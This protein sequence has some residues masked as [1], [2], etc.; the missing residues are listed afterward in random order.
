MTTA[1]PLAEGL[2]TWPSAHPALLGSS[3]RQC[4]TTTFPAQG[5]CPRCTA[6]DMAPRELGRTGTLWSFTVQGFRPKDPYLGP[7][8]FRPYGVGYVEL[9]DGVIVE[10]VL[11]E[12]DPDAL[13]I[14][15]PM[16]LVVVPFTTDNPGRALVT[17]AFRPA[18]AAVPGAEEPKE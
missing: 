18:A 13:T 4:G 17:F 8:E 16:E 15:M 6:E 3:C 9:P 14:G 7:A 1:V 12:D 2:F 5:S 11:T 10:S